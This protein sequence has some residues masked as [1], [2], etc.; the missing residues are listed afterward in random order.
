MH[1]KLYEGKPWYFER[2]GG[3]GVVNAVYKKDEIISADGRGKACPGM[4]IL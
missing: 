1:P 3:E 2:D 4:P